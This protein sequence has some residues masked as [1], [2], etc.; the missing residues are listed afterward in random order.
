MNSVTTHCC[1]LLLSLSPLRSDSLAALAPTTKN[2][3]GLNNIPS[4]FT[5]PIAQFQRTSLKKR[6][7][8]AAEN[9]DEDLVLSL[10]D[11]LSALNPTSIPTNG[12]LGYNDGSGSSA[13]LNGS[14][15]LLYTNAKDAEAPARTERNNQK[16]FGDQVASGVEV[17]T[18]QRI[19]A[20]QGKCINFIELAGEKKPFDKLEITIQMTPLNDKRV[21]LDFQKGRALNEKAPAPFLKDFQFSFPPPAFGDFLARTRGFDPAVEPPAYFD[22]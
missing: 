8:Q 22:I 18:G 16:Q 13:P 19:D 4:V 10:V 20:A 5:E 1:L 2:N 15:R 11:E 3:A 17:T 6:L 7:I 14:W 21:R 12:L 9:K